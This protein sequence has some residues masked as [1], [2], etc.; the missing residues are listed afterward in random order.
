MWK[1]SKIITESILFDPVF[2]TRR[3]LMRRVEIALK[4]FSPAGAQCLDVGCGERP[5]EYLFEKGRYIGI[6][7]ADSGRPGSM[8][9]PD[10]YYDGKT[11]PFGNDSFDLVIS[12]QVL[13][14]VPSPGMLVREMVRVLKPGGVLILTLPF[15]YPEH[16]IPYDFFRFTRY[17]IEAILAE[18]GLTLQFLE[19]DST[20]IE[21]MAVL[22]NV[23]IVNNLVP[24]IRGFS[25]LFSLIFCFPI[26]LAAMAISRVL[27]DN[28]RF[29][30]NNIICA[31]K[32]AG[33]VGQ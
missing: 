14:H 33:L 9:S 21:A 7:I 1:S 3:R 18:N 25:A 6:D 31:S 8:K 19:A 17:G 29:Y 23:Y 22:T 27:P 4:R 20:A 26:Q 15:V 13:E 32:A 5:Y 11:V 24:G 12:T 28:K 30:L 2:L 16:E 10:L